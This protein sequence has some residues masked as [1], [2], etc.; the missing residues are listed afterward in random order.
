MLISQGWFRPHR[1][2]LATAADCASRH[3]VTPSHPDQVS[4]HRGAC[5][6]EMQRGPWF[7]SWL[8]CC[9]CYV[10]KR[11][12]IC[13]SLDR[14][15]E[16]G[17]VVWEVKAWQHSSASMQTGSNQNLQ[18]CIIKGFVAHGIQTNDRAV[19]GWPALNEQQ[20]CKYCARGCICSSCCAHAVLMLCSYCAHA[21]LMLCLW[22][23]HTV[24]SSCVK[25]YLTLS[26]SSAGLCVVEC[27]TSG[28]ARELDREPRYEVYST[29][30]W[31]GITAVP[32]CSD[33]VPSSGPFS[34]QSRDA[35]V[36][37]K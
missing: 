6:T 7:K 23:A 13:R 9:F 30:C 14:D 11:D 24:L 28:Q 31:P 33:T 15:G 8:G 18:G 19:S 35:D 12:Q 29:T 1:H 10:G 34:L 20:C 2:V 27:C 5:L 32:S 17:F 25:R 36:S 21:V 3:H 37:N 4:G 22:C 16:V 26:G